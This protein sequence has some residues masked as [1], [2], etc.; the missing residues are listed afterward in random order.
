FAG[1]AAIALKNDR[2]RQQVEADAVMRRSMLEYFAP[3]TAER[4][5]ASDSADIEPVELDV[6]VLFT[7][8]V[9]FT[10]RSAGARPTEI[11]G[12]LN[13]Y[14]PRMADI[15][16]SADGML[17]KYIGDA[18]L[19]VWGAPFPQSD[20]AD[21][22]LEAARAMRRALVDLN[23][24]LDQEGIPPLQVKIGIHSGKV[25]FGNLGSAEYRQYAT[26]GDTTNVASRICDLTQ[27]EE[28]WFSKEVR[29]QLSV[30]PPELGSMPPKFV[31][32]K[33]EPLELFRLPPDDS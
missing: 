7:D 32:G 31:K 1:Q 29:D 10:A 2:L 5:L 8:I 25:A 11:I 20:A 33:D 16:I 28:I 19:A 14:F 3:K 18:L 15:V 13:R 4:I 30:I 12:L 6:T 23:N 27:P 17:E 24:D 9:G 26:I 21:R 22:A